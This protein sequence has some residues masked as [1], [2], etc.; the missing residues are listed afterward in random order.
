MV[1]PAERSAN[2]DREA[3]KSAFIADPVIRNG[4]FWAADTH[5]DWV[6]W[7]NRLLDLAVAAEAIVAKELQGR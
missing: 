1:Q 4:Y 5:S 6:E 3:K 7:S 2:R